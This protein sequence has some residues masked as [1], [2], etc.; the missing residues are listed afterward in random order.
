MAERT[1]VD[2]TLAITM[3]QLEEFLREKGVDRK[4]SCGRGDHSISQESDGRP[5]L[6]AI[7]DPRDRKSENWYFWTV[8]TSCMKVTLYSAGHMVLF[9]RERRNAGEQ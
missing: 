3:D 9:F 8:C 5:S 1:L 4:C 6:N 7:E 2:D